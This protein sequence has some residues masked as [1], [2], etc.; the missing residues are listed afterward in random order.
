MKKTRLNDDVLSNL[1]NKENDNNLNVG[2]VED[3]ETDKLFIVQTADMTTIHP[4]ITT[5]VKK[6]KETKDKRQER[7]K[8]IDEFFQE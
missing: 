4:I 2:R 5:K 1:S 8:D 6:G 3:D 7:P